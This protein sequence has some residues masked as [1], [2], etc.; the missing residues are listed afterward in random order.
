M[1]PIRLTLALAAG[2][3]AFSAAAAVAQSPTNAQKAALRSACP[4]DFRT[5]CAG[6]SPGGMNAL[7][8]LERNEAS[9]SAGCKAAVEAVKGPAAAAAPATPA[10]AKAAERAAPAASQSA[11][12]P[13]SAAPAAPPLTL[14][15]EV[16]MA[17]RSCFGDFSR[18]CP[19]LPIGH[20]NMLRCLK[21]HRSG[22][23]GAC[24]AAM[25]RAGA[26]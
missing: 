21:E 13:A 20:G 10:P 17:A 8:C 23:S 3:A 2:L 7:V 26:F 22:L 14:R 12:A 15:E 25:S 11:A 18:F 19:S 1:T 5:H 9:L 24:Q 6:V 4:A 16:R